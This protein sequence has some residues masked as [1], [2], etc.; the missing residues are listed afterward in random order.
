MLITAIII[1]T[2]PMIDV[3]PEEV[4]W[5]D[6]PNEYQTLFEEWYSP[7]PNIQGWYSEYVQVVIDNWLR[8]HRRPL[9]TADGEVVTYLPYVWFG[10]LNHDKKVNMVDFAMAAAEYRGG[11]P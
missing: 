3:L 8:G 2:M 4:A 7:D 11:I 6:D 10:D 5:L 9:L 1:I